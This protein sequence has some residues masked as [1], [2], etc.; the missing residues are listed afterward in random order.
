[1]ERRKQDLG[2]LDSQVMSWTDRQTDGQ[3][4]RQIILFTSLSKEEG[5]RRG[6]VGVTDR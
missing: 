3:T 2:Y 1:M 4:D 5:G 6:L